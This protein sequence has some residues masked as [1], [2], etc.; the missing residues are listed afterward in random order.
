[1]IEMFVGVAVVMAAMRVA[2]AVIVCMGMTHSLT[3]EKA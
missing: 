3:L 2:V 1:M